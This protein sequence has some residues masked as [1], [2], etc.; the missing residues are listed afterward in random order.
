VQPE[1]QYRPALQLRQLFP[2]PYLPA[3]H[4]A[5]SQLMWSCGAPLPL[6]ELYDWMATRTIL[7]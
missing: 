2:V 4:P 7:S 5:A 1:E 3:A 6:L